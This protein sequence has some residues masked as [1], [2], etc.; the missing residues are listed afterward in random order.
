MKKSLTLLLLLGLN[1]FF[2]EATAQKKRADSV[3][4]TI[5]LDNSLNNN[6]PVDSVYVIFDR[7]NLTAAG[8]VKKVFYPV[9][10]TVTIPAVPEGKF[11]I[12][13]LCLGIYRDS[14]SEV[15][16]VYENRKNK[17]TFQFR[18]K[19]A[20]FFNPDSILIPA[21]KITPPYFKILKTSG[22]K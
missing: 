13:V 19:P 4:V 12:T 5:R 6:T 11:Y 15:S 20:E 1:G 9:N 10:N 21:E 7:Y 16:Y 14:F 2:F 18:L 22:Q 3:Q 8:T 17:N